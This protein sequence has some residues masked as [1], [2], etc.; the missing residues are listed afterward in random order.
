MTNQPR[1]AIAVK[2]TGVIVETF[3]AHV[4]WED[5]QAMVDCFSN[6]LGPVGRTCV[7]H[8]LVDLAA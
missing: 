1:F 3:R 8:V 4:S 6:W 7:P 5:A 2:A